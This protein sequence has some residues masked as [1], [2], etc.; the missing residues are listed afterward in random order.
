MGRI[1]Y[2]HGSDT[3]SLLSILTRNTYVNLVLR[4][5][6]TKPNQKHAIKKQKLACI[7]KKISGIKAKKAEEN[8][9]IERET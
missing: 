1:Q 7:L 4:K 3:I 8:A 5:H 2:H 6:Q 9:Q